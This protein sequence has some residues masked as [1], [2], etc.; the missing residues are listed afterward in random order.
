M[1]GRGNFWVQVGEPHPPSPLAAPDPLSPPFPTPALN[2]HPSAAPVPLAT[3]PLKEGGGGGGENC[4]GHEASWFKFPGHEAL[5]D[6]HNR[7]S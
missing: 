1:E 4:W 6:D 3:T 7:T 2:P 5:P